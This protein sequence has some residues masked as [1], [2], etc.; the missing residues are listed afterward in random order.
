MSYQA[1]RD[2]EYVRSEEIDAQKNANNIRNAANVAIATKNPYAAAAGA[3][4]KAADKITSGKASEGLGKALSKAN[5][6]A[7]GG[8]NL[9]DALNKLNDSGISD[10]VGDAAF[11]Y[12]K[13]NDHVNQTQPEH[14]KKIREQQSPS[15]RNFDELDNSNYDGEGEAKVSTFAKTIAIISGIIFVPIILLLII[16]ISVTATENNFEDALGSSYVNGE[17]IG[18]Y[19]EISKDEKQAQKFFERILE[20]R[21]ALAEEGMVFESVKI[22]AVYNIMNNENNNF[23]YK[24]MTKAKITEIAKSMFRQERN[25]E[26]EI[27]YIYDEEL[28]KENLKEKIYKKQFLLYSDKKR[29]EMADDTIEYINDYYAYIGENPNEQSNASTGEYS[30]W[31]QYTGPWTTVQLGASGKNIQQ[32]GCAATSVSI[33]IAK[34]GVPTT[35]GTLNPGTFVETLSQ[36]GGF[37]SGACL[38]CINWASAASV[39]PSFRFVGRK[40]VL[41]FDR[42]YKLNVLRELL[43]QGYYVVAEVKGNTGE[44][45]VAI[46]TIQGSN[47]IMMDPGSTSTNLWQTY[48]WQNTSTYIYYRVV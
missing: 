42:E 14:E 33:L 10:K 1:R 44:H 29:E 19:V 47:I 30:T 21:E 32:I 31:K 4:V 48:S 11:A 22:V 41:G 5:Q 12:H 38:G 2:G 9:Q 40:Y 28:F 6:I 13:Y 27:I 20:V 8:Q 25:S 17:T 39:A 23:T 37:G 35:V 24:K 3:T 46:D 18:G 16:V 7:P 45:W 15:N 36:N 26:G 34:S 43:N